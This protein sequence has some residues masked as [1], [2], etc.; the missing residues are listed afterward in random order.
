MGVKPILA[1]AFLLLLLVAIVYNGVKT[2]KDRKKGFGREEDL[3]KL[4]RPGPR[5]GGSMEPGT[6][7]RVEKMLKE[8]ARKN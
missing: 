4:G 7:E 8:Q 2:W 5:S 6:I 3:N 1:I